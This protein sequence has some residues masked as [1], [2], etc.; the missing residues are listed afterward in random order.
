MTVQ[1]PYEF[2][3]RIPGIERRVP[4]GLERGT[5]APTAL[6]LKLLVAQQLSLCPS[7]LRLR[8][9]GGWDLAD[10]D[11]LVKTDTCDGRDRE[12]RPRA[13]DITLLEIAFRLRG[14]KGGFGSNLRA[15]GGRMSSQKTENKEACRDLQGRRLKTVNEAKKMA[16]YAEQ[17]G[18]RKRKEK[19][20]LEKKIA[21]GL[22]EPEKK[23]IRFDDAQFVADHEKVREDVKDAVAKG[24]FGV[25]FDVYHKANPFL[26]SFT[27]LLG[28]QKAMAKSTAAA[29]ATKAV[30]QPASKKPVKKSIW[31][32]PSRGVHLDETRFAQYLP[33]PGTMTK[34]ATIPIL[35]TPPRLPLHLP[36]NPKTSP[37]MLR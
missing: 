1:Q 37:K 9:P 29:S 21:E 32:V 16:E 25:P 36:P 5:E 26:S 7:E 27:T 14:G 23:K 12:G 2:L 30:A 11:T 8:G 17:E 4:F 18:E 3:V 24:W 6:D 34:T 35:T 13:S 10:E 20:R 33:F 15:M 19:E 28:L 31:W 22:K